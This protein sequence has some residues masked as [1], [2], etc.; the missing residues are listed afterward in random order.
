MIQSFCLN[1]FLLEAFHLRVKKAA[2]S[3][4]VVGTD[5]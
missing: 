5:R 2:P 1:F 4:A 3:T